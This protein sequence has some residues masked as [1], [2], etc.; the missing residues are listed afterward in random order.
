MIGRYTFLQKIANYIYVA[1]YCRYMTHG[2]EFVTIAL[3]KQ[4]IDHIDRCIES[5]GHLYTSRPHV[6]KLALSKFFEDNGDGN[7]NCKSD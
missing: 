6:V 1:I 7:G 5:S 2:N 4:V 3:P